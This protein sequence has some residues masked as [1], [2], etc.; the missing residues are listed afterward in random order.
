MKKKLLA[1]LLLGMTLL[2]PK[3]LAE[4]APDQLQAVLSEYPGWPLATYCTGTDVRVRAEANTDCDVVDWLQPGDV[5]Y[6][7]ELF[8]QDD[9]CWYKG[10]TPGGEQGFV[11]INF[12]EQAP[13]AEAQAERF[14]AA[15]ATDT[16]YEGKALAK[17]LYDPEQVIRLEQET[18]HYAPCKYRVGNSWL[19]GDILPHGFFEII[20][21]EIVGPGHKVA[22]LEVGQTLTEADLANFSQNMNLIGWEGGSDSDD[23]RHDWRIYGAVDGQPRPVKGFAVI[24]QGTTI[25]VIQYWHHVID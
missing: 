23:G 24:L 1:A 15:F 9:Y 6:V 25:K 11:A 2:T 20:G 12:L 21:V 3:V 16:T 7:K 8:P 18:F 17:D 19:H 10:V 22:G 14:K 4:I 5:F 13:G